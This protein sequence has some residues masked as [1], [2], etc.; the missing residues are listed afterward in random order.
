M[1]ND[2][3]EFEE[4]NIIGLAGLPGNFPFCTLTIDGM[5]SEIIGAIARDFKLDLLVHGRDLKT[6]HHRM[7]S[8]SPQP[9]EHKLQAITLLAAAIVV[10]ERCPDARMK[11][12]VDSNFR[13]SFTEFNPPLSGSAEKIITAFKP[14]SASGLHLDEACQL[15]LAQAGFDLIPSLQEMH[16]TR[17]HLQQAK[18]SFQKATI[19]QR[20]LKG[21]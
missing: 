21:A 10:I 7:Q 20:K 3:S 16:L 14:S 1:E 6:G 5:D 13:D 9:G 15:F 12:A 17:A 8:P 19:P 18:E 11:L 2:D 4:M